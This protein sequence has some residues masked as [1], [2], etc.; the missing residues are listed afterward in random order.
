[1]RIERFSTEKTQPVHVA[2][3]SVREDDG[4]ERW[5]APNLQ[6]IAEGSRGFDK[7]AVAEFVNDTDAHWMAY[8]LRC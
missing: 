4:L 1:M 8:F 5:V 6:L 7:V 2:K 3:V